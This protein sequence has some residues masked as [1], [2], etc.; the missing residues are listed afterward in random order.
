MLLLEKKKGG[1]N[2]S[3]QKCVI[4]TQINISTIKALTFNL[5][6]ICVKGSFIFFTFYFLCKVFRLFRIMPVF[7]DGGEMLKS[8]IMDIKYFIWVL[9]MISF[10]AQN[11]LMMEFKE[12]SEPSTL[13][14]QLASGQ[15]INFVKFQILMDP[16]FYNVYV[17]SVS[18]KM[19]ISKMNS[20]VLYLGIPLP[21]RKKNNEMF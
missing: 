15:Q 5:L 8:S 9:Y 12:S 1:N 10:C 6:E 19:G 3:L 11:L 2:K 20:N 7:K 13:F 4:T 18:S 14:V 21:F 16:G 17:T